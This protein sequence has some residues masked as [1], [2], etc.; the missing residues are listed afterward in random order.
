VTLDGQLLKGCA[1]SIFNTSQ[2]SR[3]QISF[4]LVPQAAHKQQAFKIFFAE[5]AKLEIH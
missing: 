1:G 4:V 3:S 5:L 2:E